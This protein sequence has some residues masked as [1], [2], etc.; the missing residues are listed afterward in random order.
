ME[1]YYDCHMHEVNNEMGGLLIA[2]DGKRGTAG[3]YGNNE[4][5]KIAS[6]KENVIPV[7]YVDWKFCQT[8]TDIVKY[9]PRREN[10]T[11][12]E[13]IDDIRKRK[14]QIVIIDTLNQ[15]DW[16]PKDYWIIAK[17][18]SDIRFLFS[19]T[20]GYDML[21]FI[22]IITYQKNVWYDFSFSQHV[23]GACGENTPLK[24]IIE[25]MEYCLKNEKINS[26]VL[27]GTD[28]MRGEPDLA[29][30]SLKYYRKYDCYNRMIKD[31]Y[32][33]FISKREK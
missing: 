18:F 22:N 17:E 27:F 24:P 19:H 20:G 31:N 14:P 12:M 10:Y 4:V 32:F 8:E 25:L 13:V 5:L 6:R 15:P 21:A 16:Q 11:P 3:G 28:N 7:Q 23:F 30:E 26:R 1:E 2:L 29:C 33:E 9:H